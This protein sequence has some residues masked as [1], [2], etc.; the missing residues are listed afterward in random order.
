MISCVG[1]YFNHVMPD[2]E[3]GIPG[4]TVIFS[5]TMTAK[6]GVVVNEAMC[7]MLNTAWFYACWQL[8]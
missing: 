7:H 4:I 5:E 8:C 1:R 2:A 3:R 6:L